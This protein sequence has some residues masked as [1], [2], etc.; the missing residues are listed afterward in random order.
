MATKLGGSISAE[1]T[2]M[3]CV[4]LPPTAP[5]LPR[6]KKSRCRVQRHGRES[7]RL[8]IPKRIMNPRAPDLEGA[9]SAVGRF[10]RAGR[11]FVWS[12]SHLPLIAAPPRHL[13]RPL[14]WTLASFRPPPC[15]PYV[16]VK[17]FFRP[18]RERHRAHW[19]QKQGGPNCK[20]GFWLACRNQEFAP[21][22]C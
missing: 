8:S 5:A 4:R 18:P 11:C 7:K 21:L 14:Y 15:R 6:Y 19:R 1:A 2:A 13:V 9:V 12:G 17:L 3:G 10:K 22:R 20:R 16:F